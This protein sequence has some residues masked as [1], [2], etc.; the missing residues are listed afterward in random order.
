[1]SGQK[2]GVSTQFVK[3]LLSSNTELYP[4][5]LCKVTSVILHGVVSPYTGLHPQREPDAGHGGAVA[6][7]ADDGIQVARP[8]AQPLCC[9]QRERDFFIE[10]MTSGRKLKASRDGSVKW[11]RSP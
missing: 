5:W 1:M 4:Q 2:S 6:E 7:V 8:L 11:W 3:S 10:L 9:L